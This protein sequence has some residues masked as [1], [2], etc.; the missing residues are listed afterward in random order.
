MSMLSLAA[1]DDLACSLATKSVTAAP[2]VSAEAAAARA[3]P[4]EP[5][6]AEASGAEDGDAEERAG[7]S[8]V[9]GGFGDDERAGCLVPRVFLAECAMSLASAIVERES[10]PTPSRD[11]PS[12]LTIVKVGKDMN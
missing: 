12:D 6:L 5:R 3:R 7:G 1:R 2:R 9:A 11:E 10:E 4:A 8:E